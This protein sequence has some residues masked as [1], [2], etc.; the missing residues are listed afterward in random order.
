M[1]ASQSYLSSSRYGYDFVVATTQSSINATMK[2]F[3][4]K[5]TEPEILVCYV[6]DS[7]GNPTPID[8]AT[9]VKNARGSD[10]FKVSANADPATNED[11][12]NLYAARYI[13][14]F[15]AKIGI[16]PGYAPSQTPDFVNLGADTSAVTYN[17]MCSEFLVTQYTPASGYTPAQWL[18]I[19][20]PNGKAWMFTSKVDLRLESGAFDSLPKD[21]QAQ[22]K[23]MGANAFS[24]QQLLF[25]LD[26]A[27]LQSTPTISGVDLASNVGMVLQ[28]D[29]LGKYFAGVKASGSPV[30]GCIVKKVAPDPSTLALT[31]FNFETLPLLQAGGNGP[32]RSPTQPQRDAATLA[33]LCAAD[34]DPLS[35]PVTFDWNWIEPNEEASFDGVIAI[36]RNTFANYFKQQRSLTEYVASNCYAPWVRVWLSGAFD[37][38]THYR[39]KLTGNQ[40]PT[41][42]LLLTGPVVLQYSYS[43]R[44]AEDDA[45]LNGDMGEMK[46]SSSFNMTISFSGNAIV[47]Q[48]HLVIWTYIRSLQTSESGHIVDRTITDT[49][50]LTVD[51]NGRL[52]TVK[53]SVM[54]DDS[55][56]PSTN[57][58][59]NFF[60]D[61][62]S[63]LDD[64]AKWSR[65][66]AETRLTDIPVGIVQDFV[67]PGGKTFVFKDGLF[68][69]N[70]DLIAHISY[71]DPH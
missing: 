19:S 5:G 62:N 12:K 23:N 31:N 7:N 29:F 8:H 16:P 35:V 21:V 28:R 27:G 18:S 44:E 57:D 61:L 68:S 47:I 10:P 55:K 67:F 26:N 51:E 15:K 33:Y 63:L 32:Y 17:L 43:S 6:A 30:L 70:Q 20:Q 71:A 42:T 53:T 38:N 4:S 36:N 22:I 41:V 58:F 48:Q 11:L 54:K 9:L 13:A 69:D 66:L 49:Y 34:H 24:V 40:S 45:G 60:T 52:V 65:S 3:L 25:D 1:S 56:T 46:L 2:E 39:W 50:T 64:V 37:T 59:L 14:G